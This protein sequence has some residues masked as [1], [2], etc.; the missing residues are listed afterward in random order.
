VEVKDNVSW[1]RVEKGPAKKSL[2]NLFVYALALTHNRRVL[3]VRDLPILEFGGHRIGAPA[4]IV[5]H[6]DTLDADTLSTAPHAF[7]AYSRRV[8]SVRLEQLAASV[9][10]VVRFHALS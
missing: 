7:P 1:L 9:P 3:A 10:A 6:A 2:S 8:W 5:R 4:K